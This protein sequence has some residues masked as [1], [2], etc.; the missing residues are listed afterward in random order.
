MKQAIIVIVG[1]HQ[2]RGGVNTG[3]IER[4]GLKVIRVERVAVVEYL[5]DAGRVGLVLVALNAAGVHEELSSLA[6]FLESNRQARAMFFS[7]HRELGATLS[8]LEALPAEHLEGFISP[9]AGNFALCGSGNA[10]KQ[11][12]PVTFSDH[13]ASAFSYPDLV[14][15]SPEML[16]L[17]NL[18]LKIA[19]TDTTILLQGESGTG[20]EVV[21]RAIHHHS[22]RSREAFIPVDCAAISENIIESELFGHVKG[23]FTGADRTTQGLIRSAD[24]GTLFL[25]EIGE[26]PM[27][28]Q[29]KLLRTLQER[30]VKPV[31]DVRIHPVD[32]RI[33]AATNVNLAEAVKQ[34]RFR[35]DLYYRLNAITIYAP[36][37]RERI[38]DIPLLAGHFMNRLV[39]EG[40]PEKRFS[41]DLMGLLSTHEWPG[42]IRELENAV[43]RAATLSSGSVIGP[44]NFDFQKA[45]HDSPE[46]VEEE[47]SSSVAFHE[48]EA[49]RKA[50]TRTRGNRR[51]AAELLDIS[52]ATLYRRLKIYSL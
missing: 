21:A 9:A 51:A 2:K 1:D 6:K 29:A 7:D 35:Q 41:P 45:V 31:G 4:R 24:R 49:I 52:E 10:G 5:P 33:V 3:C 23:A 20:K 34:G 22:A 16:K 27:S 42:N 11:G 44:E 30:A 40:Y 28:M 25:D 19:P 8:V 18:L 36:P 47:Y 46:Q 17:K 13:P 50:L 39:Q 37:L 15:Q 48:K 43:R 26:L 14:G 12:V 32:I 38:Y